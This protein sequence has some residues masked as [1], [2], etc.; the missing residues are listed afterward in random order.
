MSDG[1]GRRHDDRVGH[2]RRP[3][4]ARHR[5]GEARRSRG[6]AA[7]GVLVRAVVIRA[8]PNPS[9]RVVRTMR[10]FRPDHQFQIVLALS[11]RRGRDGAWWYRMSLP[12]PPNG[13][14]GW[15]RAD[16]VDVRPVVNRIVVRSVPVVWR[17]AVF[18]TEGYSSVASW[19]SGRRARRRLVAGSSTFSPRL[20]RRIRSS[21]RSRSRRARSPG[22][23]T[24]RPTSSESTGQAFRGCSDRRF[25]T[26]ASASRTGSRS[27]RRLAPLGTPIDI[28]G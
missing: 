15:V 12:G 4:G 27:L 2:G 5:R 24:G 10:R 20:F 28:L 6:P 14:R 13:G 25:R 19:R 3:R 9:A 21:G 22:S 23:P 8:A 26:G 17:Y 16:A 7:A 11:S 1:A 18:A